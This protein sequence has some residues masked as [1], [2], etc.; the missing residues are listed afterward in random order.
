MNPEKRTDPA[1]RQTASS[2]WRE[3]VAL[4]RL[5]FPLVVARAGH[6]LMGVVDTMVAGRIGADA[7]GAVGLGF[8]SAFFVFVLPFGILLGLDPLV[9]QA[10]GAKLEERWRGGLVAT[11]WICLVLSVPTAVGVLLVPWALSH[12]S[13]DPAVIVGLQHYIPFIAAS[14]PPMLFY[15]VYATYLTAHGETR[16]FVF[17]TVAVNLLNVLLN[18]WFVKGGLGLPAMGVAGIG[19]ATLGCTIAELILLR[20]MLRPNGRFSALWVP[21]TRPH[22]GT[23]SRILN[24]GVPVGVQYWMEVAGFTIA[25]I[26]IGTFGAV[27]LAGHQIALNFA[28]L[29]FTA[30]LGLG[31]AA[32]V[33]VGQAR[34][35]RDADGMRRA[36][37]TAIRV[38]LAAAVAFAIAMASGRGFIAHLYTSDPDTWRAATG[39]LLIA[40]AFQLADQTQAIGF[41]VLRGLDDTKVPTL[42][43]VV[44]YW[45]VGLPL[46]C[47]WA[48]G[49]TNDPR[50]LWWGLTAALC[51]VAVALVVR[52]RRLTAHPERL[53]E[54]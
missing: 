41:G 38:G 17:I 44:A 18:L 40:A 16:Q 31:S 1:E 50:G 49:P 48:F 51:V 20:T 52:F 47:W 43:N 8:A 19:A 3:V 37:W 27:T 15:H 45:M 4:F 28:G 10:V 13:Q 35:R 14:I 6:N 39:F 5:A 34:G 24:T 25:S 26:L 22:R 54:P 9:S 42:F 23:L 21:W 30:A 33:R 12:M 32:G 2:A 36:G 11:R 29:A 7:V 46:G 53:F